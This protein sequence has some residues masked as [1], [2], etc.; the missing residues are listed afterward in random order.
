MKLFWWRKPK[1]IDLTDDE[2]SDCFNDDDVEWN[3]ID[4]CPD[5]MQFARAVIR[6]FKE[7]QNG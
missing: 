7:K 6:K 1:W 2:I 5:H 3:M 4:Y